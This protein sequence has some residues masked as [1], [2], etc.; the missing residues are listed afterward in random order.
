M[1]TNKKK[2]LQR[3][4]T[5]TPL[6]FVIVLLASSCNQCI[7]TSVD[8]KKVQVEKVWFDDEGRFNKKETPLLII[9]G[10][11]VVASHK[12][13][14]INVKT[15]KKVWEEDKPSGDVLSSSKLDT[16]DIIRKDYRTL[17]GWKRN[18]RLAAVALSSGVMSEV[19]FLFSEDEG[20]LKD[21]VRDEGNL[22]LGKNVF[23]E[24]YNLNTGAL[25]WE[26]SLG[27]MSFSLPT[28]SKSSLWIDCERWKWCAVDK[29]N[30]RRWQSDWTGKG[31]IKTNPD[32]DWV[33]FGNEHEVSVVEDVSLTKRWSFHVEDMTVSKLVVGNTWVA[34][35][36]SN[37]EVKPRE[38]AVIVFDANT[39]EV[40]WR[41]NSSEGKYLGYV[42]GDGDWLAHYDSEDTSMHVL[43][44][45]TKRSGIVEKF[46]RGIFLSTESAGWSYAVPS[47]DPV[48]DEG[49]IFVHNSRWSVYQLS[50]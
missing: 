13:Y 23:I 11:L 36:M 24:K 39:G 40:K 42:G 18:C 41:K 9:D 28:V 27:K 17:G 8:T 35:L 45:P 15:K 7:S 33:V 32:L 46:H 29:T 12:I 5:A 1:N 4:R 48:I 38:Y 20:E 43:H 47:S 19:E 2:S 14:R 6:L 37:T 31:Y 26:N 10:D 3:Q 30:G 21:V 44:V 25:L 16:V 49:F 34:A 50:L 22:Y